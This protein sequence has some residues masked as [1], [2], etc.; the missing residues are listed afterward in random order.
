MQ[1]QIDTWFPTSIYVLDGL[2][3][4]T[5]EQIEVDIKNVIAQSGV[6]K[7]E[8]LTVESTHKTMNVLHTLPEFNNLSV[9]ILS[10]AKIFLTKMG[11]S[12]EVSDRLEIGTMWTNVSKAGE[13]VMPHIH[14]GSVLS[15]VFYVKKYEGSRITFFNDVYD[16][17]P[18]EGEYNNLSH[19]GC[20]YDCEPGRLMLWKSNLLHGTPVQPHGEKI[21]ISFNLKL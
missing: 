3:L 14:P 20:H 18:F 8:F 1:H 21:V 13:F 5:L 16:M 6:Y 17:V 19:P 10:N 12:T 2:F 11:W 4:D 7:N 9:E 15:G